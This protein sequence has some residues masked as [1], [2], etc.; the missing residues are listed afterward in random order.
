MSISKV[1]AQQIAE[2][3]DASHSIAI[4]Q[5]DNPDGDSLAS[6]LA[7]EQILHELGI[8]PHLYCGVR[9]P[10][11]LRYLEGWDRVHD[12]LP[13]QF[14][15]SII[16]DA[17]SET[18]LEQLVK[19]GQ[20]N[21]VASKP[22]IV[23]D[24]HHISPGISY[25]N[26][27]CDH[28][29]V[30]TGEVIYE[31]TQMLDWPL[32][33][34]AKENIA[35]SIMSD[36]LGLVSEGTSP[37]SIHIIGDLVEG[38]VDLAKIDAARRDLMRKSPELVAYK[39]ALLQRIEYSDDQRVATITIPWEEI[40]KYS[41]AYNPSVLVLDD[42]RMTEKTDVAIAFKTYDNG[43]ITAKI[44]C[45][46]NRG[47]AAKLAEKFGGG[48]HPYASGFKIDNVADYTKIKQECVQAALHLLDENAE[49]HELNNSHQTV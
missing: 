29:A 34:Q 2:I 15:A 6:A 36:S 44:R 12:E 7:L 30:A 49:N 33:R 11:H 10:E 5:A 26:I 9:M 42:M 28:Q 4:I 8:E 14:D 32:N 24:H 20:K 37:R 21:W 45:N 25:A 40:Q 16:V 23:I 39:G 22:C 31:L 43:R 17:N 47:I 27:I 3:I 48:G 13:S 38:G 1:E 19:S 35:V 18:L 46:Y 41:H